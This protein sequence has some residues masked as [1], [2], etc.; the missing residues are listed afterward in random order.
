MSEGTPSEDYSG[1]YYDDAH[2]GGYDNYSWDNEEWR[3]FFLSL[4]DRVVGI[5]NPRSVLD[6]GC[7]RGLF[8]QALAAK[9]LQASGI[10]I[11]EHAIASA[12]V[13]VRDRLRVAS[14]TEPFEGHY[15]LVACIEVL[16]HMGPVDAQRAIDNIAAATD[17]VLFSSSPTDHDEPTHIN[18]RPAEQWAAWFAERGFFRRTDVDLS[19]LSPWAVLFERR[20]LT[21]HTL[22]HRYEQQLAAV[23]TELM[24]KRQ[25]LLESHRRISSL[26]Q[27]LESGVSKKMAEQAAQVEH[28]QAE[29]LAARHQLLT[30]RDHVIGTEAQ[31][32]RLTGDEQRLRRE[33]AQARKQL[34]NVRGRLKE[35]RG[36]VER[37]TRKN[38]Q[39]AAEIEA[40]RL[41]PSFARRAARKLL[42]GP[43]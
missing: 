23:N 29:V 14:A 35:T 5:V 26:N 41:R 13:D 19:F 31:V 7:A 6:V 3:T 27:Q 42:G 9:G 17:L 2:L 34:V 32:A 28:W 16:E 10:D 30:T 40:V 12:H 8:V 37:L 38:R 15:D 18:T 24:E 39:L 20:E 43:R 22:A 33:L 11:S 1:T 36:R 4:A 21:L 25:A